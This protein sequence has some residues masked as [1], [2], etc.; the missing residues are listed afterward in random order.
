MSTHFSVSVLNRGFGSLML[1]QN[2]FEKEPESNTAVAF[3]HFSSPTKRQISLFVREERLRIISATAEQTLQSISSQRWSEFC[4]ARAHGRGMD[5]LTILRIRAIM[6]AKRCTIC[7]INGQYTFIDAP[8]R[9]E[10]SFSGNI[11]VR[12]VHC[13]HLGARR[14]K[15]RQK[16]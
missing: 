4:A 13:R 15:L 14:H 2:I 1:L 5:S 9:N 10:S 12:I 16:N 7:I 11:D 8:I 3:V 6:K